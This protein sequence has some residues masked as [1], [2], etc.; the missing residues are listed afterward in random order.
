MN[1][2][3]IN[4][5]DLQKVVRRLEKE[6]PKNANREYAIQLLESMRSVHNPVDLTKL[7]HKYAVS[8]YFILKYAEDRGGIAYIIDS[9]KNAGSPTGKIQELLITAL[10][11][12]AKKD[13]LK[14]LG[15]YINPFNG[16]RPDTC[17]YNINPDTGQGSR[18]LCEITI[19]SQWPKA[20]DISQLI[21]KKI[22]KE[23]PDITAVIVY[24]N[25]V[26]DAVGF[27]A[28]HKLVKDYNTPYDIYLLHGTTRRR[29]EQ[30][31]IESDLDLSQYEMD[32]ELA[33][34]IH[35]NRIA[36]HNK[37]QLRLPIN[38][39]QCTVNAEDFIS[40]PPIILT[41]DDKIIIPGKITTPQP[42]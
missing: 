40:D 37:E 2:Y 5:E 36:G 19:R 32:E 41:T 11:A 18:F 13:T 15:I 24:I 34:S 26:N 28:L 39:H 14:H 3:Q 16:K 33:M 27:S 31:V 22:S 8:P 38:I 1:G 6:D 12:V 23:Y 10:M 35:V 21:E 9:K 30:F 29:L 25:T 7:T 17:V 20:H 4:E 42:K